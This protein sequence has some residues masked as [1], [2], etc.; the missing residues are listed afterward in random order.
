MRLKY[1][2]KFLFYYSIFILFMSLTLSFSLSARSISIGT[3]LWVD[4]LNPFSYHTYPAQLIVEFTTNKLIELKYTNKNGRYFEPDCQ[5]IRNGLLENDYDSGGSYFL[6]NLNTSCNVSTNDIYYTIQQMKMV[7]S[8]IYYAHKLQYIEQGNKIIIENPSGAVFSTAGLA[9]TFPIIKKINDFNPV[10]R[11]EKEISSVSSD[12][13]QLYNNMTTGIYKITKLTG[14]QIEMSP[15]NATNILPIVMKIH[16]LSQNYFSDLASGFHHVALS[17]AGDSL[18]KATIIES[19]KIIETDDL[20]SATFFGFN[21][22]ASDRVKRKLIKNVHFRQAFAFV[23]AST[24]V[25]KNRVKSYGERMNYTFDTMRAREKDIP[26]NYDAGDESI[27]RV[28]NFIR[29]LS[30]TRP[31]EF[32][33][34][35]KSNQIFEQNHFS[36]MQEHLNMAFDSKISFHF[37]HTT[38]K[39]IFDENKSYSNFDIIYDTFCYGKNKLRYVEFLNPDNHS[40]NY[41]HCDVFTKKEITDFKSDAMALDTFL[42][43]VNKEVPVFIIGTFHHKNLI[44]N[45]IQAANMP[46]NVKP[47]PFFHIHKWQLPR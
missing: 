31:I 13:M 15:R 47:A 25:V 16:T 7:Q 39:G 6:I 37:K 24:E 27:Y 44:H 26:N 41:L 40:L 45:D 20:N 34:V 23:I 35:C 1:N 36:E 19:Y 18:S 28:Q 22:K 9:L 21:Y 38:T 2:I 4:D 43:R 12:Q 11:M 30:N 5:L 29:T 32:K 17:L 46:E 33:V 8:N 10:V 14:T 3:D 42:W